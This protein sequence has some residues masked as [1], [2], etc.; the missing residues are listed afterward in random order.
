MS[1]TSS[2]SR[3]RKS[4]SAPKKDRVTPKFSSDAKASAP[5]DI[6]DSTYRLLGGAILIVGAFLRLFY[7]TLVPLHHDEGVNGNFLVTL[8]RE[9][10]YVYDPQNYHGPTL[11]FFSSLIPWLA[12]FF[13]G[14]QARDAYGL[15]TFNIRLV[16]A[17]F[18]IATIW[19]ALMLRK[20]LGS[21]GA[22]SAAAL[23]GISPG[24]IYLSRYFI[25][26]TLFVFFTLGIIVAALKYYDTANS[27]YMILAAI[28]AGLMVATKETWII[29]G[30]VLL[31]ALATTQLYFVVRKK[32]GNGNSFDETSPPEISLQ[33]SLAANVTLIAFAI[34]IALTILFVASFNEYKNSIWIWISVVCLIGATLYFV[35]QP[36]RS[37]AG[38]QPSEM[39][40]DSVLA[41]FGGP[42]PLATVALVALAI[43]ILV[44]VL[45]YSSFFTNYPKGVSDAL[46]TLNLWRQRT[47]EHEHPWYQYAYWLL[48]EEGIVVVLAGLGTLIAFWRARNRLAVFLAL[49]SFGLL[50]AYS[51]AGMSVTRLLSDLF[52]HHT[53]TEQTYKT[54]W[55]SLNFVVPMA[56]TAGYTLQFA[57]DK[58]R[59][60]HAVALAP[61]MAV[62]MIAFCGY[63]LYQ[64]N[65]VH[66][67]DDQLPYV[68]AHTKRQMLTMIDRIESIA[69]KNGTGT[70]T[71]VAIVSPDYWPL[72]WYFRNYKKV[73]YYQQIVP[74]NE[75]VIIAS[76]AQED[77]LAQY[78]DRYDVID[79]GADEGAYPLRPG[80]DL[81]LLVRRDVKR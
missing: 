59:E 52:L 55:I 57:Y 35:L 3:N 67:D 19:L 69:Q 77:Q 9:G 40:T 46:K 76:K 65:F 45:F 16:T 1:T 5:G 24:A 12:R 81:L 32:L 58:L 66:Y 42:I 37:D 33:S 63:Q 62:A 79:S 53:I 38:S 2:K 75:P 14:V 61:L 13:G 29:N 26:E 47:H 48:W 34:F 31:I 39:P 30:P 11:Y 54:P 60:Y 21:I 43:F 8:V 22:L 78:S 56:L 28:S 7:L 71:G 18:G 41:R 72:P 80:V 20:R 23:I 51:I 6:S 49:W 73:G 70:D 68:Y 74:T 25:H 17:L 44:N 15:T 27:V 10:K 4:A 36:R 64:L 50:T